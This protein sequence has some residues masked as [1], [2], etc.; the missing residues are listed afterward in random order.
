MD[1]VLGLAGKGAGFIAENGCSGVAYPASGLWSRVERNRIEDCT[2]GQK[3]IPSS[4]TKSE[5]PD[6][7]YFS[8]VW[9]GAKSWF[10]GQL[11]YR[12][13]LLE[14]HE[15]ILACCDDAVNVLYNEL[16]RGRKTIGSF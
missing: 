12:I 16:W 2:G 14:R 7:S 4:Q 15:G 3:K 5:C 1:E 6:E 9:P 13:R 11:G 8:P 10:R